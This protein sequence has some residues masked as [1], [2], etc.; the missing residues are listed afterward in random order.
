MNDPS[1]GLNDLS[2]SSSDTVPSPSTSAAANRASRRSGCEKSSP[3]APTSFTACI[4][5]T[6]CSFVRDPAGASAV[7]SASIVASALLNSPCGVEAL[8]ARAE[9]CATP[10]YTHRHIHTHRHTDTQTHRRTYTHTHTDTHRHTYTHRHTHTHNMTTHFRMILREKCERPPFPS[11]S[12][13]PSMTPKHCQTPTRNCPE[14][15]D[16]QPC[17][18]ARRNARSD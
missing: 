4:V 9:C 13:A 17:N 16:K 15:A 5:A 2:N 3:R 11:T 12:Q 10:T 14:P 7:P 6:N 1:L 18:Q 8:V